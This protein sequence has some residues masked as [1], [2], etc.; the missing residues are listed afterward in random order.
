MFK[1]QVEAVASKAGAM[2]RQQIWVWK[3]VEEKGL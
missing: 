1:Q 3:P 2:M